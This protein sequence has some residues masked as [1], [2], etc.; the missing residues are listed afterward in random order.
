MEA[1]AVPGGRLYFEVGIGQ[2]DR[3]LRIMRSAGFGDIQVVKDTGDIPVSY[4]GR[5]VRRFEI[6]RGHLYGI[7]NFIGTLKDIRALPEKQGGKKHGKR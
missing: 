3:V 2:A 4:S 5:C 1:G 7:M 6:G